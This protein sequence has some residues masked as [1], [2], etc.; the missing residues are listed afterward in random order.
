[1]ENAWTVTFSDNVEQIATPTS[2]YRGFSIW[3]TTDSELSETVQSPDGQMAY[4]SAFSPDG[5]RLAIGVAAPEQGVRIRD[6]KAG[7]Y[8]DFRAPVGVESATPPIAVAY[9]RDGTKLAASARGWRTYVFDVETGDLLQELLPN[10][11]AYAITFSHD[12]QYLVTGNWSGVAQQWS[13]ETG[14]AYG[15]PM[16]HPGSLWSVAYSRDGKLLATVTKD[17]ERDDRFAVYVWLVGWG[18]PY[19][20]IVLPVHPAAPDR[21]NSHATVQFDEAG[22]LLFRGET[23][24]AIS[25][26]PMPVLP[27]DLAEL[28]LK[29]HIALGLRRSAVGTVEAIPW[30]EWRELRAT[31]AKH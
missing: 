9:S 21:G 11:R 12:S 7:R 30:Q 23:A 2:E 27:D 28:E 31:L 4:A 29:T 18:Y 20:H 13:V 5:T 1:P 15:P 25:I 26:W 8:F 10:E 17:R 22:N 6:L 24:D 16:E 14:E 3:D 19:H